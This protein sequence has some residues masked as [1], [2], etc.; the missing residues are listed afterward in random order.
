MSGDSNCGDADNGDGLLGEINSDGEPFSESLSE[1]SSHS[2]FWTSVLFMLFAV[3][4]SVL[5][6][7]LI[8]L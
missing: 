6:C 1:A 2:I 5:E 3:C 8:K 4:G 7:L